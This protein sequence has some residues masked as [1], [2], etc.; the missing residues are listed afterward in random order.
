MGDVSQLQFGVG[1]RQ[2]RCNYI[3]KAGMSLNT[4]LFT[5]S[6]N[7]IIPNI[8]VF[9]VH[10]LYEAMQDESTELCFIFHS[11]PSVL[12]FPLENNYSTGKTAPYIMLQ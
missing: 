6:C 5:P 1:Q 12:Y 10:L 3:P 11:A 2:I 7:I 4:I 8:I 9:N